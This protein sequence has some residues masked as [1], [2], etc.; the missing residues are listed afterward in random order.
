MCLARQVE[1][2]GP[3][4][5][6]NA[7]LNATKRPH[8]YLVIDFAPDTGDRLRIRTCIFPDEYPA[9]FYVDVNDDTDK[10]ELSRPTTKTAQPKLRKAIISNCNGELINCISEYVLNVLNGNLHVSE[11]EKEKLKNIKEYFAR[12]L[13]SAVLILLRNDLLIKVEVL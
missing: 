10:I 13:I 11:C 7:Y 5:L 3:N 9:T 8:G 12:L 6:Y 2:E 4:K 1:S